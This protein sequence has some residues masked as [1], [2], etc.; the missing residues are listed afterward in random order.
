MIHYSSKFQ[1]LNQFG[2]F[3]CK[4]WKNT[5]SKTPQHIYKEFINTLNK[6]ILKELQEYKSL[7]EPPRITSMSGL[8]QITQYLLQK[9]RK[10]ENSK[11]ENYS[12]TRAIY[13]SKLGEGRNISMPILRITKGKRLRSTCEFSF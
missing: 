11:G 6:P 2:K 5:K 3:I 8:P 9:I 7:C 1:K 13:N 12:Y 10:D 4:L